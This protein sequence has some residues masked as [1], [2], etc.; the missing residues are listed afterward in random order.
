MYSDALEW[1]GI[2]YRILRMGVPIRQIAHETGI[3]R[4]TI[5]KM[6]V[7]ALPPPYGPRQRH[8]EPPARASAAVKVPAPKAEQVR[9]GAF[10]WMRALLQKEISREAL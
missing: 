10:E 7:H 2:R 3:S 9:Q 8:H 5:R 6:L 1:T 4:K